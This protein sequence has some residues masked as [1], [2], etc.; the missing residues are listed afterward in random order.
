MAPDLPAT[1]EQHTP[2]LKEAVLRNAF[3]YGIKTSGQHPPINEELRP[4]KE[5]PS[6]VIGPTVWSADMYKDNPERWTHCFSA[7][8]IA[9]LSKAADEFKAAEI[10]L[11]GISKAS[12]RAEHYCKRSN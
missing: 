1:L 10:P 9:E 2:K 6:E 5:F 4:Y 11:T 12:S 8:E 3:P 7:E